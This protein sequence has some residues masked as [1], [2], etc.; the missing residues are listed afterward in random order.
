MMKLGAC[1]FLKSFCSLEY[2]QLR[3]DDHSRGANHYYGLLGKVLN[4]V[5][6][7]DITSW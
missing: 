1:L 6:K 2:Y 7:K 4:E 5:R 3:G